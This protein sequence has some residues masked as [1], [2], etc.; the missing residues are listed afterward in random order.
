M[1][2]YQTLK[3]EGVAP[4]KLWYVSTKYHGVTPH[5]VAILL[6]YVPYLK[7]FPNTFSLLCIKLFEIAFMS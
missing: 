5:N 1:N 7:L 6:K 4:P 2:P 3:M